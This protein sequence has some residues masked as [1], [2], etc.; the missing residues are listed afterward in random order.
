MNLSAVFWLSLVYLDNLLC[1]GLG[2]ERGA[3]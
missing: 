1:P 2:T 3:G